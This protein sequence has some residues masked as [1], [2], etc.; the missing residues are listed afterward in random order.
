MTSLAWTSG[1]LIDATR[2][3]PSI[4]T[5]IVRL[6]MNVQVCSKIF[7]VVISVCCCFVHH[8]R[9]DRETQRLTVNLRKTRV[10]TRKKNKGEGSETQ[11][12]KNRLKT[13]ELDLF[14]LGPKGYFDC[15]PPKIFLQPV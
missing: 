11:E 10:G 2:Q 7:L 13:L 12:K 8:R 3:E 6:K 9:P 14:R 4:V 15:V 1:D 5:L